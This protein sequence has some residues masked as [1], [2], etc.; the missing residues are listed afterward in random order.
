MGG[1]RTDGSDIRRFL[2][3]LVSTGFLV[4]AVGVV[5]GKEIADALEKTATTETGWLMIGWLISGPPLLLA[6]LAWHDRRRLKPQRRLDLSIYLAIWIGLSMLVLPARIDGP[7]HHFGKGS[8]V[9]E[10][11][12]TG[13]AWGVAGNLVGLLFFGIVL[14]IFRSSVRGRPTAEQEY[15]TYRFLEIGWLLILLISL[16]FAL[17]ADPTTLILL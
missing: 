5:W 14:W 7:A 10:P 2:N 12:S 16:A 6:V 15:V 8:S 17:Y 9:A 4:G 11:L 3:V 1:R 13:W